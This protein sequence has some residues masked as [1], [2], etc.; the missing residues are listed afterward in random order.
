VGHAV[1]GE[2]LNLQVG[3]AVLY[4]ERARKANSEKQAGGKITGLAGIEA[5][6]SR[7]C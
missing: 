1:I 4:S 7:H 3:V 5:A 6:F 2:I